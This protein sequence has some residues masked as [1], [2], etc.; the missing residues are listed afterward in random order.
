MDDYVVAA[1]RARSCGFDFVDIK[2]C[3]GYLG[4]EFLSARTRPGPYGGS[5]ENRTRF[6]R[7]IVEGIRAEVPGLAIGTRLSVADMVPFRPD[8]A[9]SSPGIFGQGVPEELTGLLP[10]LYGF[11]VYQSDPTRLDLTETMA[12]LRILAE[13]EIRFVN[14]SIGSPY[15]NPHIIRPALYPTAMRLRRTRWSAWRATWRWCG[16]LNGP[17][18]IFA[19]WAAGIPIC[20]SSCPTSRR[21]PCGSN[22]PTLS[23]SAGMVLAYPELPLDLLSGRGMQKKRLCRIFSDCTT[24][25]RNNLVSGCYPLDPHYKKSA[26][27]QMLTAMKKAGRPA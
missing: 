12:L 25:P 16:S 20:R 6:L 22:G 24:A 26:E 3:H 9:T 14:V 10:Y 19:S 1:K 8:P 13:L 4:H 15:Y 27:F 5:L 7:E 18:R 23:A 2:H 17:F 21:P 11:G